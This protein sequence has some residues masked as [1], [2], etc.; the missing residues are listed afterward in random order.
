[1]SL[2]GLPPHLA[3]DPPPEVL[4][5]AAPMDAGLAEAMSTPRLSLAP[6]VDALRVP[7]AAPAA[8]LWMELRQLPGRPPVT[9]QLVAGLL[10]GDTLAIARRF[11]E[12]AHNLR[13]VAPAGFLQGTAAEARALAEALQAQAGHACLVETRDAGG[14][15]WEV[16]V[17]APTSSIRR[18]A[19]GSGG[20][21][22]ECTVQG[23]G[24]EV[25]GSLPPQAAEAIGMALHEGLLEPRPARHNVRAE[26]STEA[27]IKA[28]IKAAPL[29]VC[30]E[31][32]EVQGAALTG[33]EAKPAAEAM[34]VAPPTAHAAGAAA[35]APDPTTPGALPARAPAAGDA[36]VR[37]A[38]RAASREGVDVVGELWAAAGPSAGMEDVAMAPRFLGLHVLGRVKVAV[39]PESGAAGVGGGGM[40][41][42]LVTV[43]SARVSERRQV[44]EGTVGARAW[45]ERLG[46]SPAA[47]LVA[48]FC[49][50]HP[51]LPPQAA[52]TVAA[53][54]LLGRDAD[55]M[56]GWDMGSTE[57]WAAVRQAATQAGSAGAASLPV[58]VAQ[59]PGGASLPEVPLP[60]GCRA[61]AMRLR[62]D[63]PGMVVVEGP[64][65]ERRDEVRR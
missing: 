62:D 59:L 61:H 20:V 22:L 34:D 7:R 11:L 6:I 38:E 37:G 51:S 65:G 24:S 28:P 13:H 25:R 32:G 29:E 23:C 12:H 43:G 26:A 27:A 40:T 64:T 3:L 16:G 21:V 48:V 31:A 42:H 19:R 44:R 45:H 60:P 1:M 54:L 63:M 41:R 39:T 30:A 52:A 53:R 55:A 4:E 9:H 36:A 5:V 18:Q 47:C 2:A 33:A 17:R 35:S 57:E 49:H 15:G 8:L 50:C 56:Q 14:G 46:P 58:V 10:P